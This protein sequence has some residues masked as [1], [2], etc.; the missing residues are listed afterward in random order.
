MRLPSSR[1]LGLPERQGCS[2]AR[3]AE[4]FSGV[5]SFLAR[6]VLVND[7]TMPASAQLGP[8]SHNI[9]FGS[10]GFWFAYIL[11]PE[12]LVHPTF[13]VLLGGGARLVTR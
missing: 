1:S 3:E 12:W 11:G 5:V 2:W 10:G 4:R 7:A 6:P 13:G 8:G 9:R